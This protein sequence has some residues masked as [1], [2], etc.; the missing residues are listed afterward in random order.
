[1]NVNP[2]MQT[3]ATTLGV[4]IYPTHAAGDLREYMVYSYDDERPDV[5]GDDT[6]LLD[7]TVVTVSRFT[8]GDPSPLKKS[9]RAAL[10]AL[11]FTITSTAEFYED[12]TALNHIA[13]TCEIEGIIDD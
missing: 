1:M 10:R 6:D 4:P 5:Y 7:I 3:L 12:D 13:V 11:G 9:L 2:Q 8:E